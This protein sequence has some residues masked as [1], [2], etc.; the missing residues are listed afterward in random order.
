MGGMNCLQVYFIIGA[1]AGILGL[2]WLVTTWILNRPKIKVSID[3]EYDNE[4]PSY[5][6]IFA[7]NSGRISV[8]LLSAELILYAQNKWIHYSEYPNKI[9]KWVHKRDEPIRVRFDC[10]PIK[11]QLK[12]ENAII[13]YAYFLGERGARFKGDVPIE[14]SN[15]LIKDN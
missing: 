6:N 14:Y 7:V 5:L 10:A 2:S 12:M 15:E 3:I 8:H 11:Q 1:G 13:K 4:T 9:D